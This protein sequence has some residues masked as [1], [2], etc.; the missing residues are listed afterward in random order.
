[1]QTRDWEPSPEKSGKRLRLT[2]DSTVAFRLLFINS[3]ILIV[4]AAT[5]HFP[6]IPRWLRFKMRTNF[7]PLLGVSAASAILPG[8]TR[9]RT[10]LNPDRNVGGAE[11]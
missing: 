1:V 10:K 4:S 6:A 3:A 8:V 9:I 11:L 5:F 7:F 2:I